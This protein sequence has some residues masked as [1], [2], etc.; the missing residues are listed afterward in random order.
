MKQILNS[1]LYPE[2]PNIE[3]DYHKPVKLY[4][5]NWHDFDPSPEHFKVLY[6]MEPDDVTR[7]ADLAI[8]GHKN[9]DVILTT[10]ERVLRLCP[11][12][13]LLEF[14]RTWIF[15]YR[16]P[17]KE[18]QISHLTGHKEQTEGHRLRKKIYYKQNR[19]NNPIDFY[20][21][22]HGGIENTFNSK[23][24]GE[25][26]EPLFDSQFHICIE[27]TKQEYFFSEKLIDC[28]RTKTI[29]IYWGTPKIGEYFDTRGML[30]VNTLQEIIDVCNNLNKNTYDTMIEH[31]EINNVL[32]EKF[33]KP[34]DMIKEVLDKVL[35]EEN[36]YEKI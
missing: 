8:K 5:D 14:G 18:F 21:S 29:P 1:N 23:I 36:K 9:F 32:A 6:L 30:I 34:S 28:F 17:E 20:V 26:K 16:F 11:N 15:D 31:V 33:I 19:I 10:N 35:N 4:I 25:K 24:L 27:N 13:H 12:A 3:I 22:H 2:W 7:V